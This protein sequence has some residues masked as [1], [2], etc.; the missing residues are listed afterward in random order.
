MSTYLSPY[1]GRGNYLRAAQRLVAFRPDFVILPDLSQDTLQQ[2][3]LLRTAYDGP[4]AGGDNWSVDGS[5]MGWKELSNAYWLSFW[6][7]E[8]VGDA[9]LSFAR[10][11]RDRFGRDPSALAAIAHDGGNRLLAAL[12]GAKSGSPTAV[13]DALAGI[14]TMNGVAGLYQFSDGKV[15]KDA[16][17]MRLEEGAMRL[18]G[19]LKPGIGFLPPTAPEKP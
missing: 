15:L 19:T 8:S 16:W 14:R 3:R 2:I 18:M 11:Y 17:I 7:A 12:D 9:A 13:R 1:A 5:V 6:H 10:G 4:V